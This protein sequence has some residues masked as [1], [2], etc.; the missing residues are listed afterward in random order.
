M[1]K[2]ALVLVAGLAAVVATS[3]T[4]LVL[5]LLDTERARRKLAAH[6]CPL[7]FVQHPP[8]FERLVLPAP[9]EDPALAD[10][11]DRV[12]LDQPKEVRR[13]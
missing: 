6:R 3:E 2:R 7:P 1:T 10:P 5:Q 4:A 9:V 8:T 12:L 11:V 13:G